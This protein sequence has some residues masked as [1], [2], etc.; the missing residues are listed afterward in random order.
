MKNSLLVI[1]TAM[2]ATASAAP[3]PPTVSAAIAGGVSAANQLRV[4][5]VPS[6]TAVSIAPRAVLAAPVPL[7]AVAAPVPVRAR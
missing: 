6:L 3:F 4:S 2:L 5:A 1:F 7:Q